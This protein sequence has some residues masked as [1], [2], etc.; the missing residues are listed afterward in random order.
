MV[1]IIWALG[2]MLVLLLI[3][4]IIPI[5]ITFKGKFIIV[6][7]S[8]IISLGGLI[9]VSTFSL[10]QI[11]LMLFG[12]V[13]FSAYFMD[14]RLGS[15]LYKINPTVEKVITEESETFDEDKKFDDVTDV[16]LKIINEDL[17]LP[18]PSLIHIKNELNNTN[19][20]I[21]DLS[22]IES[23]IEIESEIDQEDLLEECQVLSPIVLEDKEEYLDDS[24][25]DFLLAEK[26]V[27]SEN[28]EGLNKMDVKEKVSL[29]K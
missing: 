5:G 13:F 20:A 18:E 8:F 1:M 16:N 28:E 7:A 24:L 14:K 22:T 26:E 27:A 17:A 29:Q 11:T 9:S 10:W 25:F 15:I 4:S 3:L 2:T 21:S 6:L 12:L 19:L 23:L